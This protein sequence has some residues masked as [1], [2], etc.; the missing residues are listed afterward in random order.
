MKKFVIAILCMMIVIIPFGAMA[1]PEFVGTGY[2][3]NTNALFTV[4][5]PDSFST[6]TSSSTCIVSA[7]GTKNSTMAVYLYDASTG[8]YRKINTFINDVKQNEKVVGVSGLYAEQ[9]LLRNGLNKIL[10]YAQ[11]GSDIQT[12]RLE[13]TLVSDKFGGNLK[14][15][16]MGK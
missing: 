4:L 10:V 12:Q 2:E 5:N 6:T 13:V 14:A 3:G 15:Y 11:L 7:A 1:A 16:V 9:V 8:M